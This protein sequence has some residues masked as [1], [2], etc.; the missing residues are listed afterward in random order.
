MMGFFFRVIFMTHRIQLTR[1]CHFYQPKVK[2]TKKFIN[3]LFVEAS[4][5][6]RSNSRFIVKEVKKVNNDDIDFNYSVIVDGSGILF[7]QCYT[8]GTFVLGTNEI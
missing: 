2:L 3:D 5:N 6:K 1:N 8:T 4:K 7:P